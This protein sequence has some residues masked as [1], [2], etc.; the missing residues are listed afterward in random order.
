MIS[1][2]VS[3][4]L[5]GC[6]PGYE[7]PEA[8][9]VRVTYYW[10]GEPGQNGRQTATGPDNARPLKTCAVDPKDFPYGTTI[11]IPE[12]GITVKANDTGAWVKKRKAALAH[13]KDVPVV[14]IFVKNKKESRRLERK[15]PKFMDVTPSN[16]PKKK[17]STRP[18][19]ILLSLKNR[20]DTA[21]VREYVEKYVPGYRFRLRKRR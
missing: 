11:K 3:L 13:G 20:A 19:Q 7:R 10:A 17:Q 16:E 6:S 14:D 2:L 4:A 1:I 18:E 9:M 15:Y 8:E 5:W 12:M 21:D